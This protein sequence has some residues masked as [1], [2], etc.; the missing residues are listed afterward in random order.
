MCCKLLQVNYRPQKRRGK[1]NVS[2]IYE[3]CSRDLLSRN[4][5]AKHEM[6]VHV[7]ECVHMCVCRGEGGLYRTLPSS[8][9]KEEKPKRLLS[10]PVNVPLSLP[11]LPPSLLPFLLRP[12]GK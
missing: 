8:L 1:K 2:A 4:R 5:F 7:C 6:C 3:M 11:S 9:K 10:F 12:A